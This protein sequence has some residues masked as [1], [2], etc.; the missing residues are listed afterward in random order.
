MT[1]PSI[2]E[3]IDFASDLE[4][5]C[6]QHSA[7][8]CFSTSRTSAWD[9]SEVKKLPKSLLRGQSSFFEIVF[10]KPPL[11]YPNL[12][13]WAIHTSEI[14]QVAPDLETLFTEKLLHSTFT[15]QC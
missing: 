2:Q 1:R 7:A 15:Q 9:L 11:G 8:C 5:L 14:G 3:I 12:K 13:D 10:N 4:T 6:K